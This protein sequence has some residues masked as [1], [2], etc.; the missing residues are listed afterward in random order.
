MK[1]KRSIVARAVPLIA[2][3][4]LTLSACSS[5]T[6]LASSESRSRSVEDLSA[7]HVGSTKE[8]IISGK[9]SDA[10]QDAVVLVVFFDPTHNVVGGCTGTLLASNLVLTARHCVADTDPGATCA[11]DG[12][13]I[14]EGVVRG[15]HAASKL[16]V[17]TGPKRPV[18]SPSL[19]PNGIGSQIIDDAAK[20]LCNHDIALIL[21][22][23]PIPNAQIAPLRLDSDVAKNDLVTAVGWGVTEKTDM[24]EIRQ[25]RT[26]IKV[27]VVGPDD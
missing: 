1:P 26:G 14:K 8:A 10:S 21:L 25:Q 22:Q 27:E 15:D 11:I 18:Y 12:T 5:E 9:N 23:D 16:Y 2:S 7:E 17:F 3:A 24:P 6:P 4:G 20:N 19:K 13:P